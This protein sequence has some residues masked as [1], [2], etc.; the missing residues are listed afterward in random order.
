MK[1]AK[2]IF[3]LFEEKCTRRISIFLI[4]LPSQIQHDFEKITIEINGYLFLKNIRK[5]NQYPNEYN[6]TN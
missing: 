6:D 4:C 1:N 5:Q 3:V 2:L